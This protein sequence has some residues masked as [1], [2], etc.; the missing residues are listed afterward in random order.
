MSLVAQAIAAGIMS[1]VSAY[2]LFKIVQNNKDNRN[3][4]TG[5]IS[6]HNGLQIFFFFL[7]IASLILLG[8]VGFEATNHCEYLMNESVCLSPGCNSTTVYTYDYICTERAA[9]AG[10]WL[11]RLPLYIAYLSGAYLI[12]Y[13]LLLFYGFYKKMLGGGRGRE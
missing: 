2:M 7:V 1:F 6:T 5:G 3:E 8:R 11:Y 9:S 4:D 12:I 10:S 13:M